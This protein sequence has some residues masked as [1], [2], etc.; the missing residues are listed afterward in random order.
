MNVIEKYNR[1]EPQDQA[2]A[3]KLI[4]GSIAALVAFIA[5]R[6]IY[7]AIKE[8]TR[9]TDLNNTT[10]YSTRNM[11]ISESR[12]KILADKLLDAMDRVGTDTDMIDEVVNELQ[13]KDDWACVIYKFG[14]QSYYLWGKSTS[15]SADSLNLVGWFRR[16]LSGDRLNN[17]IS[18]LNEYNLNIG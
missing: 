1:M 4:I 12:A 9:D 14:Y 15:S 8:N 2:T 7:N 6:K 17:I 3:R 18:K 10:A 5:G 11:S 13:N 16:E